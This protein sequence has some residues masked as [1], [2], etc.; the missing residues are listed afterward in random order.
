MIM[1]TIKLYRGGEEAENC[2]NEPKKC[3]MMPFIRLCRF[4]VASFHFLP[5]LSPL[6]N[7][8]NIP[9]G[10]P[11]LNNQ[12]QTRRRRSLWLPAKTM[13]VVGAYCNTPLP[14]YL[15]SRA[16][17]S[18]MNIHLPGYKNGVNLAGN[19]TEDNICMHV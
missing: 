14:K 15:L 17:K 12:T 2:Q 16:L 8:R 1:S 18:P 19:M 13:E 7:R 5:I 10:G 3:I 11:F 4:P 6:Q 9:D